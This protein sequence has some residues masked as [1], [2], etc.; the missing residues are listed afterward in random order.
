[1]AIKVAIHPG[2]FIKDALE[3]RNLKESQ[4]AKMVGLKTSQ[5]KYIL[6]G[7]SGITKALA[8]RFEQVFGCTLPAVFLLRS[9]SNYD[10]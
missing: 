4:L 8:L 7:K 1:M 5:L 9:Q 3:Y 10:E 6:N 2:E